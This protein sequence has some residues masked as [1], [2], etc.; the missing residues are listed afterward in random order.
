[1]LTDKELI[2]E[3]EKSQRYIDFVDASDTTKNVDK[4]INQLTP[5]QRARVSKVM[6]IEKK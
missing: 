5:A 1:M 4:V 2:D 3:G 6:E